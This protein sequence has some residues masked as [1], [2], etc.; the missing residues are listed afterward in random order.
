[1]RFLILALFPLLA[2]PLIPVNTMAED[3]TLCGQR[4]SDYMQSHGAA[5]EGQWTLTW[6]K[7]LVTVAGTNQVMQDL[8]PA[9]VFDLSLDGTKLF[10]RGQTVKRDFAIEWDGNVLANF[11][12]PSNDP[13]Y[14]QFLDTDET[15]VL[16]N[17]TIKDTP[18]L[19]GTSVSPTGSKIGETDLHLWLFS[20]DQMLGLSVAENSRAV[21]RMMFV[22]TRKK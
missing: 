13:A 6:T 22:M 20:S 19:R 5:L 14:G 11:D 21:A 18:Y 7:G 15:E 8:P 3:T 10:L 17:C 9:F 2:I 1:M 12:P 16:M 4:S